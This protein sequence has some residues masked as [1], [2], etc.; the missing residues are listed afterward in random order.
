MCTYTTENLQK[1]VWCNGLRSPSTVRRLTYGPWMVSVDP[2]TSRATPRG[3]PRKVLP[4]LVTVSQ[5]DEEH[6]L[7]GSLT[8]AASS[9]EV[10]MSGSQSAQSSQSESVHA[11][12]SGDQAASSDEA[13]SSEPISVPRNDE[14]TPVAGEP[15]RWCVEG[16]WQI[17]RDA[18]MINDKQ[19]MARIIT[20]ER[21]VLTG[22]WHT[23][24]KIHRLF[25]FHK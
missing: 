19:K 17:Y 20:E 6:T 5:S 1:L 22:N 23:V 21:R 10:Q 24:P 2:R 15:N 8:G 14:L 18:K 4:D 3:I 16:Q 9:S 11:S 12:G 7:I 25:N 13:T